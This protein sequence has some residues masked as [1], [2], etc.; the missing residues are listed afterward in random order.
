MNADRAGNT[1]RLLMWLPWVLALGG[2]GLAA[3][4]SINSVMAAFVAGLVVLF[5]SPVVSRALI[6]QMSADVGNWAEAAIDGQGPVPPE[7]VQQELMERARHSGAETQ[8]EIK[9]AFEHEC[10]IW[11][12]GQQPVI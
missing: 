4:G 8:E 11:S 10:R 3:W 12:A 7:E 2:L 6:S 1:Q 5:G 9:T